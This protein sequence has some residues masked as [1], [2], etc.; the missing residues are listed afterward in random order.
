MKHY[1]CILTIFQSYMVEISP[2]RSKTQDH[3]SII[4]LFCIF[5]Y[6]SYAFLNFFQIHT[7]KRER[8]RERE[9]ESLYILFKLNHLGLLIMIYTSNIY[10]HISCSR[11][12]YFTL[13]AYPDVFQ[14]FSLAVNG[15]CLRLQ[16]QGQLGIVQ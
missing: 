12:C 14:G 3:Q 8:K 7:L 5:F 4:I 6:N 13:P 9:I 15:G 11:D 16:C 10:N 1:Q 2:I